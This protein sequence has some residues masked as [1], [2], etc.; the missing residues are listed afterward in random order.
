MR[1]LPRA[2]LLETVELQRTRY[3]SA[4]PSVKGQVEWCSG[5]VSDEYFE[6]PTAA[7]S[8]GNGVVLLVFAGVAG[9]TSFRIVDIPAGRIISEE[10]AVSLCN[11]LNIKPPAYAKDHIEHPLLI[12]SGSGHLFLSIAYTSKI[13]RLE[14]DKLELSDISHSDQIGQAA[15][16]PNLFFHDDFHSAIC[17]LVPLRSGRPTNSYHPK[18][19]KKAYR[20]LASAVGI[21]RF[22]IG[23]RGGTVEVIDGDG[24]F[25]DAFRPNPRAPSDDQL[26]IELSYA[27][28][29]LTAAGWSG[30]RV[31]DLSGKRVAEF[32]YPT[33]GSTFDTS[34]FSADIEYHGNFK[35]TDQ[36]VFTLS[37]KILSHVKFSDLEWLPA[38]CLEISQKK[39]SGAKKQFAYKGILKNVAKPALKLKTTSAKNC[40]SSFMYGVPSLPSGVNWPEYAG[41]RMLLICEVDLNEAAKLLVESF[42][43]AEGG[44]LFFIGVDEEGQVLEDEQFN[45]K[46]VKVVWLPRLEMRKSEVSSSAPGLAPKAIRLVKDRS[47]LPQTDAA[48]VEAQ[49][50]SDV[51]LEEYREFFEAKFPDGVTSGNRI[52]GYP[53]ILQN[54]D[55]EAQ[56]EYVRNGQYPE[57]DQNGW[58]TAARW[59]L[60]LQVDSDGEFMWGTDSGML[61]FM[62]HEDDL[63]QRDFS[64]VVGICAGL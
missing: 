38:I 13:L 63:R 50:F 41:R 3:A 37:R 39:A 10:T 64:R 44:L 26:H 54:N 49:L 15:F 58:K 40:G 56:A 34:Q 59:R 62:I 18:Y 17:Q 25:I 33:G 6:A 20:P 46:A 5:Q 35:I 52:G 9:R 36:G 12:A 61:Y 53:K 21:D 60:L 51:E 1:H 4:V 2:T 42:L 16:S 48:I 45:P 19:D 55:L 57:R 24:I 22:A 23:H 29:F 8:I 27:G 14:N 11:R 7:A 43:P 30:G 47:E 32:A 28:N 31:I